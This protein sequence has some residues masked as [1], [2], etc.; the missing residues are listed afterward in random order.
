MHK[1]KHWPVGTRGNLLCERDLAHQHFSP[2]LL[3]VAESRS[4]PSASTAMLA[5]TALRHAS[6][7]CARP[8]SA[9]FATQAAAAGDAA[10]KSHI[11]TFKIYRYNPDYGSAPKLQDYEVN[12][13]ECGYVLRVSYRWFCC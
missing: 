11:K 13:K 9:A 4:T 3:P 2:K 12:L 7:V 10:H 1:K 6:R 5:R 8:V